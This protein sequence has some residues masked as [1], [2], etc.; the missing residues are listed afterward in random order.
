MKSRRVKRSKHSKKRSRNK[1]GKS[2]RK[3]SR[4][5]RTRMDPHLGNVE[6]SSYSPKRLPTKEELMEYLKMWNRNPNVAVLYFRERGI[7]YD[8]QNLHGI[9]VEKVQKQLEKEDQAELE[10]APFMYGGKVV[11]E[12]FVRNCHKW[13]TIVSGPGRRWKPSAVWCKS[14]K[15]ELKRRETSKKRRRKTRR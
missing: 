6:R 5:L 7:S 9:D 8:G 10:N 2:R 11:D 15:A 12:E 1:S 3:A 4:R 13:K 14:A